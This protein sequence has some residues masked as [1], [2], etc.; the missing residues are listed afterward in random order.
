MT[1]MLRRIMAAVLVLMLT[2][3]CALANENLSRSEKRQLHKSYFRLFANKQFNKVLMRILAQDSILHITPE[4]A[5]ANKFKA[6]QTRNNIT[7]LLDNRNTRDLIRQR[8]CEVLMRTMYAAYTEE[9]K[10]W[11][12]Q[13]KHSPV[14]M[15]RG[16]SFGSHVEL[17]WQFNLQEEER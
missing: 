1:E 8:V 15:L 13:Q 5:S 4:Q 12:E 17:L 7:R 9:Q 10:T 11:E 3:C 2:G 6:I 14:L 16:I